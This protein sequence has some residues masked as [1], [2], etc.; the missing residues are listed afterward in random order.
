MQGLGS[1]FPLS[2]FLSYFFFFFNEYAGFAFI[3]ENIITAYYDVG[4]NYNLFAPII[5]VLLA[6]SFWEE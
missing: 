2:F 6:V 5:I 3:C 4:I 1:G